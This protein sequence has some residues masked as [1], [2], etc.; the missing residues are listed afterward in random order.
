MKQFRVKEN[1]RYVWVQPFGRRVSQYTLT[2]LFYN[3]VKNEFYFEDLMSVISKYIEDIDLVLNV[4][5]E[6]TLMT[7]Y[8]SNSDLPKAEAIRSALLDAFPNDIQQIRLI[9]NELQIIDI[10][11]K[12]IDS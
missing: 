10:F 7:L 12:S 5:K 6:K 2:N 9:K 1:G 11:Y 4:T 8:L 3:Y